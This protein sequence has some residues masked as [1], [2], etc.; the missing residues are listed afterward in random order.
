LLPE[1]DDKMVKAAIEREST[2]KFSTKWHARS[3]KLLNVTPSSFCAHSQI[4]QEAADIS[5]SSEQELLLSCK[6]EPTLSYL[7]SSSEVNA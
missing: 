3:R 7:K 1:L 6:K 5:S 2:H 4:R